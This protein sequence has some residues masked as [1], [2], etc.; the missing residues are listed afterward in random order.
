M[1]GRT[2]G[3]HA[4][5]TTFGAKVAL[6]CL[7][8]DRDR[9]RLRAARQAVAVCK[10]SGAVGT[11]SNID[12]SV[13]RYVAGRLGLT[14]VPATQVIARD[15]HAEF[16]WVC[17][18]I[19]STAELVAV[20]LRHLQRTEVREVEEGFK[21][22]QKGSSA[23]PH[24]RNPISAET[25]SGL[26]RVLRGNLQ[27]GMQ[28]IALWHERDISHSSVERIVL[29]DSSMLAHYVVRRLTRLLAGLQV[30][31]ERMRQNLDASHGLVFSQPVLLTL[32]QSG[33]TRDDAYRMVQE[34]A[35]ESWRDGVPF[36]G[37][38]ERDCRAVIEP[39]ALDE[40][41]DLSR[42]LRNI[43]AVFEALDAVG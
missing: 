42:S 38:V 24:K 11:Y 27:A 19:G 41:F 6:W 3:V 30:F 28:N 33:L 26:S 34:A 36:R 14:P 39:A 22:G 9:S 37:L 4:E 8:A 35:M 31:P 17:A 43:G 2:H 10:L 13:E 29:P 5:P 25:I 18:S 16:L 20:E 23:M 7:Q 1:I 21:A 12:P 32:V 15:R 40:A